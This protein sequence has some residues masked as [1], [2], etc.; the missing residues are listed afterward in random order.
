MTT[1]EGIQSGPYSAIVGYEPSSVIASTICYLLFHLMLKFPDSNRYSFSAENLM[2][3]KKFYYVLCMFSYCLY[4]LTCC[5]VKE[6]GP[7][8]IATTC[9]FSVS[10]SPSESD[11]NHM[12]LVIIVK[13]NKDI[14][15][16]I[17]WTRVN[18][19]RVGRENTDSHR[20]SL[21]NFLRT[22]DE[23][24]CLKATRSSIL[25]TGRTRSTIPSSSSQASQRLQRKK[26]LKARNVSLHQVYFKMH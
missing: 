6:N 10:L 9:F 3:N 4:V 8:F 17:L 18:E 14:Q 19:L 25:A 15:Q 2:K 23:K 16:E 24:S 11:L 22:E 20:W 26:Y 12:A 13:N 21:V 1:F 5:S 7:I